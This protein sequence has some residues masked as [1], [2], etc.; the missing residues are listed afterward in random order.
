LTVNDVYHA[1]AIAFSVAGGLGTQLGRFF[2]GSFYAAAFAGVSAALF[3]GLLDISVLS[4][5][6]APFAGPIGLDRVTVAVSLGLGLGVAIGSILALRG[7]PR[8]EYDDEGE[9]ED[10]AGVGAEL[11]PGP[12][13]V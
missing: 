6:Q 12:E 7:V 9:E 11:T 8:E 2:T 10:E 5:S 4:R 3:T 1:G 13:P